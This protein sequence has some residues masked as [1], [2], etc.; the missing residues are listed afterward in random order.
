MQRNAKTEIPSFAVFSSDVYNKSFSCSKD[1]GFEAMARGQNLVTISMARV[2]FKKSS[3]GLLLLKGDI[4]LAV[5]V[6][7]E[8]PNQSSQVD[9]LQDT[10]NGYLL[11]SS[12]IKVQIEVKCEDET[13]SFCLH[14]NGIQSDY[15]GIFFD[16]VVYREMVVFHKY[17]GIW[18]APFKLSQESQLFGDNVNFSYWNLPNLADFIG[19]AIPLCG[20]NFRAM[21][22]ASNNCF[23][24]K[25]HSGVSGM[26][27]AEIPLLTFAFGS[28]GYKLLEIAYKSACY[29]M[30]KSS[31][32]LSHKNINT[33]NPLLNYLGWCSW[34][35]SGNG[36]RLTEN[37][38]KDQCK[39]IVSG[40]QVGWV[41]ID[42][43]WM[44]SANGRAL[45]EFYPDRQRFP[46]G[47]KHLTD[48]LKRDYEIP[49]VGIWHTINGYWD[50]IAEN[51]KLAQHF[52]DSLYSFNSHRYWIKPENDNYSKFFQE[53][54]EQLTNS[55]ISFVKV[56]N[57]ASAEMLAAWKYPVFKL[58]EAM[59]EGLENAC[60]KM[61]NGNLLNCMCMTTESYYN[62]ANS[63]LARASEDYFPDGSGYDI[64][65]G[66]AAAHVTQAIYNSIYFSQFVITDFDMFE[67][68]NPHADIHAVAR[69]LNNGPIYI[70]DY[71]GRNDYKLLKKL[72]YS[73]GRLVHA[74]TPLLPSE[75]SLFVVQDHELLKFVSTTGSSGAILACNFADADSV[76]GSIKVEDVGSTFGG[77]AKQFILFDYKQRKILKATRK[78]ALKLT[79]SRME[80]QLFFVFPDVDRACAIGVIEKFNCPA[81]IQST[82]CT[83]SCIDFQVYEGGETLV[84]TKTE[85]WSV[86]VD[87]NSSSFAFADGLVTLNIGVKP[88]HIS[89]IRI[90][91]YED[92]SNEKSP[93]IQSDERESTSSFCCF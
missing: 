78:D 68:Y 16:R 13:V 62:F 64:R 23:G 63:D 92:K 41:L 70:T 83:D 45:A 56:D 65:H 39:E 34:N 89:R 90:N 44:T 55:G 76:T 71:A 2:V 91:F 79:L 57:Q 25:S 82:V 52:Q 17:N 24:V 84:Y 33:T 50:G 58:G 5:G 26:N 32:L 80:W 47:L 75:D 21:I 42:D 37:W 29:I 19:C 7:I 31:S 60:N 28:G 73:D 54:Y 53:W 43:G 51:S 18:T 81:T 40:Q 12:Q 6:R 49:F 4:V 36:S 27:V 59:H 48:T 88:S 61:L 67:T 3:K 15:W 74:Q 66:N 38:I 86:T 11:G 14:T 1:P 69:S 72:C 22:G 77:T 85:P 9:L 8:I 30:G 20:N 46:N 87:G 10:P 35:S 93:L